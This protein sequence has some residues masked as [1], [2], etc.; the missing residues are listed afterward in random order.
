MLAQNNQYVTDG[1]KAYCEL[2]GVD[3]SGNINTL[4]LSESD[5]AKLE[6]YIILSRNRIREWL[7]QHYRMI[8]YHRTTQAKE[9]NDVIRDGLILHIF[10]HTI[11]RIIKLIYN[12]KGE[13]A[14]VHKSKGS[15]HERSPFHYHSQRQW[16]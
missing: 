8:V 1:I 10:T 16:Y 4:I 13:D 9:V 5:F 7:H 15:F 3:N 11:F 2:I 6:R 14:H 12:S